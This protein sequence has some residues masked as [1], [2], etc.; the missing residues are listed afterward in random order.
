[1]KKLISLFLSLSSLSAFGFAQQ[2]LVQSPKAL[3]MGDAFTAVNDDSYT[4]FYNP[5]SMARHKKAFSLY[6]IQG[7]I[8]GTNILKDM[9]RF[10]DFPDEPIGV[11][12]LMMNYPVHASVGTA[13]GFKIY[14]FGFN[15]IA[16]DSYDALLRN[17]SH[18]MLDVDF[19][20]DRGFIAG[21]A[22]PLGDKRIRDNHG[23]QTSLG[24]SAKYIGR[25]GIRDTIALTG[26]TMIDAL[27]KDELE[28]VLQAL[29]R[30]EGKSWG[31]DVGLEHVV[32]SRHTQF[33]AGLTYL[34]IGDTQFKSGDKEVR[35][36]DVDG[37]LNLGVAFG[38]KFN[39]FHYVLSADLKSLNQELDFQQR[40][41]AG[42]EVGIPGLSLLAGM[43]G[44]YYS[45]GAKLNLGLAS[46]MAGFYDLE[47]GHHYQQTKSRRMIIYLSLFDFSF[48]I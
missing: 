44:G 32:R 40:L 46:L 30:T 2:G 34:D 35:M 14:N 26:P 18:P 33:V 11:A 5:A 36:S 27:G 38:Q 21:V 42:I 4:L 10:K 20:S 39:L 3:L 6:P 7:H 28:Q 47:I 31:Y 25:K 37:R 41:K 19:K 1:M 17:K 12:D 9:D 43:N 16:N 48:D 15:L 24:V 29:G 22:F 13:P 45:Y 23:S 8:S